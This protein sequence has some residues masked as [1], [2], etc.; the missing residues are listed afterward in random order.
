MIPSLKYTISQS[1]HQKTKT[2]RFPK[3]INP[4]KWPES[5]K[6]VFFKGY[7]RLQEI[8]L[9]TPF[10]YK[11]YSLKESL[12]ARR[13]TRKFSKTPLTSKEVSSLL[14][15]SSGL[16]RITLGQT[17]N[18]FYPSAGARYPLEVYLAVLNVE[19]LDKGI[20]HYFPKNH[21]L[22]VL[23]TD[24][25]RRTL[26]RNI[27]QAWIKKSAVLFII[28]AV[29]YRSEVKYKDRGYRHVLTE[30]GHLTQNLYLVSSALALGCCSFAG[31]I[32]DGVNEILDLD[33]LEESVVGITA[34]GH[35]Q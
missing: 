23:L 8:L 16:R 1:F 33:G 26:F 19:G 25:F 6:K 3:E 9:P 21:S 14:Y 31:Y 20:Y 11:K 34:V 29:F 17:A 24:P 32:D 13:S 28:S 2:R 15:Y 35:P 4:N 27:G 5:W 12:L 10:L 18:R 22:E 7:P 30:V